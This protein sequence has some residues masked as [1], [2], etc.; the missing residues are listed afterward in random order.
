MGKVKK[1]LCVCQAGL[2]SSLILGMNV[3]RVL[4]QMGKGD[5]KVEHTSI[6]DTTEGLADLYIAGGDIYEQVKAFGPTVAVHNL[7]NKA[8]IKEVLEKYF[9]E[10]PDE[11]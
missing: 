3:E 8:E 6:G 11:D 1:I 5:I 9:A 10:H 7:V 4:E 2:G